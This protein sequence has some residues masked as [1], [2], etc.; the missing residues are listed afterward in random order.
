MRAIDELLR[1]L[2]EKP[3]RRRRR[4]TRRKESV[5]RQAQR[6]KASRPAIPDKPG[7]RSG[8]RLWTMADDDRMRREYPDTPT[9]DLARSLGRTI[10]ALYGRADKLGLSKSA[11][12][13]AGP[14]ACR[15]RRGDNVGAAF[16]FKPGQTP[17][18]KGIR[19][20]GFGPGRMKE[21][22]FKKGQAGWNHKPVGSTRLCDG[23]V[24][25]KVSDIRNVPWTRNWTLEHFLV[26]ERA[27][28]PVPTSHALAFRDAD[29]TNTRLDNLELITR[30]ELMKRNTVHNL[31]AP[32]AQTI[33]LLGALNRQI[34]RRTHAQEEHD[35]R[36]A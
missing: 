3:K 26:W 22:Q 6:T 17:P 27:N 35:R 18:N 2:N 1:W 9:S 14:H 31:P 4:P 29:R 33:Q 19:R 7:Y 15:L 10:E 20:P 8:K 36:S 25:R 5:A 24:Y 23:Y 13:L 28:G 30:A 11:A 21:T 34:R 32:L 12:Y 16:R